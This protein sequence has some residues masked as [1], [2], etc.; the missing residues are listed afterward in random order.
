GIMQIDSYQLRYYVFHLT[1]SCF[2]TTFFSG[3]AVERI[4]MI[5]N[6]LIPFWDCGTDGDY[7]NFRCYRDDSFNLY[8]SGIDCN[9]LPTGLS[10]IRNP[11]SEIRISPNPA[12]TTLTLQSEKT[13]PPQ[14]TFQL[15]DL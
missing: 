11:N 14:T 10:E 13:L 15:F 2:G 5:D 9:Y 3:K 4:G 6:D 12:T 8:P 1:D 7:Y